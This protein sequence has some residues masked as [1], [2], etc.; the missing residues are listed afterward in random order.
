MTFSELL[1]E[2][3]LSPRQY[4]ERKGLDRRTVVAWCRD[5]RY[6]PAAIADEVLGEL[7]NALELAPRLGMKPRTMLR[8]RLSRRAPRSGRPVSPRGAMGR[9]LEQP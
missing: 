7:R 9:L 1:R 8:G 4:A 3:N 6:I 5:D 2:V